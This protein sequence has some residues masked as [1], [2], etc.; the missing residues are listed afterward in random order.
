M[1]QEMMKTAMI[2]CTGVTF[3]TALIAGVAA[4]AAANAWLTNRREARRNGIREA[5]QRI[6]E[7][8]DRERNS[9]LAILAEKDR[10]LNNAN[11]MLAKLQKNYEIATKVLAAADRKEEMA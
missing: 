3:T 4:W 7:R 8:Y 10:E 9:W 6:S 5:E 11:A 1:N 2:V